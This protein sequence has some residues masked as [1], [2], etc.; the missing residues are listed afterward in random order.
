VS[1]SDVLHAV[2]GNRAATIV[3][4]LT[5]ND[6]VPER[7]FDCIILTQTLNFVYET[8]TVLRKLNNMLAPGGVILATV[9][10][11]SQISRYD[12]DRWGDF[13]RFTDASTMRLFGAVFDPDDLTIVTY[14][15]VL[16]ACAFLHGLAAHELTEGELEYRD[17]DYQLIIAMRA[18]RSKDQT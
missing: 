4:D 2:P 13:W 7:S 14:G 11:I 18:V 6:P 17:P 10:G 5:K 16:T 12:M 15:N 1:R 3:A 9:A 8:T